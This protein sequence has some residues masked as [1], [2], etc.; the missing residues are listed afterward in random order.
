MNAWYERLGTAALRSCP[1]RAMLTHNALPADTMGWILSGR[2]LETSLVKLAL[3]GGSPA[4]PL[5]E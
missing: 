2:L 3:L 5:T 4:P 1:F